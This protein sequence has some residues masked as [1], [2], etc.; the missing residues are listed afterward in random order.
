MR[1]M[2]AEAG[3]WKTD[4]KTETTVQTPSGGAYISQ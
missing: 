4:R 3:R 1:G 2:Q